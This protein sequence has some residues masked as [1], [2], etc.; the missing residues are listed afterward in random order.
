MNQNYYCIILAGGPGIRIWPVSRQNKPKQF[1]D[2]LGTGETLIQ[3]TYKRFLNFIDRDNIIVVTDKAYEQLVREQLPDLPDG[4]LMLE[5]MKRN[6]IPPV[7]WASAEI[8]RRNPNGVVVV[9]PC[10]QNITDMPGGSFAEEM[11]KGLDYAHRHQ[12]LLSVGVVPSRPEQAYG[13][14]MGD[15]ERRYS[16]DSRENREKNRRIEIYIIPDEGLIQKLKK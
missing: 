8:N 1:I 5:P 13:Y 9:S 7:I 16:N 3:T 14:A 10:D 6:T 4:N 15:H 12:R 11:E 2:L